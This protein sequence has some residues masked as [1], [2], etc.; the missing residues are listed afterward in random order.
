MARTLPIALEERWFKPAILDDVLAHEG[1][2]GEKIAA[3]V[4]AT[5]E[6]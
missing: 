1:F 4:L 5:L 3:K 2:T 6:S